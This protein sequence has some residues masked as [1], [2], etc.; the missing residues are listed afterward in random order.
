MTQVA[1]G[2]GSN[3]GVREEHLE[4]AI[5]EM[6][7]CGQ[8]TAVSSLYETAPIGVVEQGAFLNAVAVL[9]VDRSPH[10]L[11]S[12]LQAIERAHGRRR[13][14]RWGPR[15]LDLDI[16]LFGNREVEEP[17]LTIPH[18][19]MTERRF[20]LQPLLEVWPDAVLPDGTLL[21]AF[22]PTVADQR[23][24]TVAANWLDTPI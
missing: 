9:A 21:R 13:G 3:V 22:V 10:D 1:V 5:V 14:R 2:L 11:L 4:T 24:R 12:T 19:R 18:P 23:V 20:V 6:A 15:S 8:V 17:G 7:S 16:L